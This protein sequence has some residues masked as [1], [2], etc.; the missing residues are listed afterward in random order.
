MKTRLTLAFVT[1]CLLVSPSLAQASA[2]EP[3]RFPC[4]FTNEFENWK[5]PDQKTIYI[6]VRTHRFFRLDLAS[7]CPLL[8]WPGAVLISKIRG[9][10]NICAPADWDIRVAVSP[11]GAAHACIVRQMTELSPTEIDALPRGSKP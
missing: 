1:T 11:G 3:S 8:T 7:S 6:R 10:N 9:A 4:F 5:A 2:S